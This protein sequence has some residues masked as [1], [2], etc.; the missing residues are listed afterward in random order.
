MPS[1]RN[2]PG[3]AVIA[4]AAFFGSSG[5][6]RLTAPL[7]YLKPLL[8]A[9]AVIAALLL[10]PAS[11]AYT[12]RGPWEILDALGDQGARRLLQAH[13]VREVDTGRVLITSQ[14]HGF[15]VDAP[16]DRLSDSSQGFGRV[17][18]R[19]EQQGFVPGK[20]VKTPQGVE[21]GKGS[22]LTSS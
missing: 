2:Q 5:R 13:P 14:N 10:I 18:R 6:T 16:I 7:P 12:G 22:V 20:V 8:V 19:A 9:G 1:N 21:T 17:V 3:F 11:F 15:A 4:A